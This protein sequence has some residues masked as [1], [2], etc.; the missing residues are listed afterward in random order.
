MR[1]L[2]PP[3]ILDKPK[4]GFSPP[5]ESWY[6]GLTMEQIRELLLD[7]RTTDRGYFQPEAIRRVLDEHERGRSNNRLLIWS[8]LCFEWWNRL[9]VD[10]E[11]AA[12]HSA[13][14]AARTRG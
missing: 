13:W 10:G 2:L 5:D 8:L 14:H 12:R 7:R 11:P 1:G 6:R 4:Q 3:E 9:F